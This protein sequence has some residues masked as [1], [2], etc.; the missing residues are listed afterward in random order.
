MPAKTQP[1]EAVAQDSGAASLRRLEQ[2]RDLG[3]IAHLP[4]WEGFTP[5]AI[6]PGVRHLLVEV[7]QAFAALEAAPQ[8]TWA[9][10]MAPLERM[11][12]RLDHVLGAV[13][14]LLSVKYSDELKAAQDAVRPEYVKLLNRM[15]QSRAVYAAMSSLRD[16]D[17]FAGLSTARQRIL[18][19]SISAMQRAGVHLDDAAKARYRQ[20]QQRLA[21][22]SDDFSANLV[23]QEQASRIRVQDPQRVAGVPAPMLELAAKT[24]R[25]DG[26]QDA[27]ARAG[28][29][30]FVV[31][32]PNYV[33]I[34]QNAKER[35]LR[36]E[37]YR[38]YRARGT[39]AE[40][41]NRPIV[42]EILKLR[43]ELATLLGFAHYAAFSVDDKMAPS[44]Q[45][46]WDLFD[47]LESAARPA[48]E[49]EYV[50]LRRFMDDQGAA[51]AEDPQAW[52]IAF[53]TERLQET[54]YGYDEERLRNYFQMPKVF[55][56]LFALVGRL[57]GL[58]VRRAAA[59]AV[60][61]W[62]ESVRF[63]EVLNG[64][65]DDAEIIAGL[66][67]DPYARPGE[68]RGGAWMN[69][70]VDR[71]RLLAGGG[72]SSSLPVA[73][74]VMNARPPA[75]GAVALM[76]LD[77]VRTLF[78][79][80]G[81]A[82]QHMFTDI[83]DGGASGLNLVEWDAVELASQFNEYW[84]DH[85]P[86]LRGLTA[87]KDSGEALDEETLER[88]IASRNFMAGNATLRQLQFGKT[89]M[90]LHWRYGL[91]GA[92]EAATP[93]E[94][95]ERIAQ[96]TVVAPRLA[97]ET[98]L[99]SFGHLFSGGYAA[100]YYSYKWAEVLA[101]DA[102]AAFKEVGLDNDAAVRQV[103][104]RFRDTVLG[105]GGSLPAGEVYRRF[106]GRDANPEALLVEQGLLFKGG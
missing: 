38:A 71:S 57:Y 26:A 93:Y 35:S 89:D 56:G 46:V 94:I 68:K 59:D 62:D 22:L 72:R 21:Q 39:A 47:Q 52:D 70:V 90:W 6:E 11:E 13:S 33:A 65:G 86:F 24:A 88:I 12:Q 20:I 95:E 91:P 55:D 84:M 45:A 15:S 97:G 36:E 7:A 58:R 3:P 42:N 98:M 51:E 83:E 17:A 82:M 61:V 5:E 104:K 78:H 79:E 67:V 34:I 31:N 10:L 2:T 53:W 106:R 28:P 43:Q 81:H 69:T 74:F 80:F 64:Q 100:G 105:L 50:E 48:A 92:E 99:P 8:P 40:F 63:F 32:G 23:K 18:K 1:V 37:I 76:S 16:G 9:G 102:F 41:D 73:L 25:E 4:V 29:W 96:A 49:R 75:E 85:R 44:V 60:P 54:R 87:H 101:A 27:D 19:E 77:E 103:A 14:H 66:Y 30:H